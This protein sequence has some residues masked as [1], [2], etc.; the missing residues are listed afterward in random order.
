M[1]KNIVI[2]DE[3]YK[4]NFRVAAVFIDQ[5]KVLLQSSERDSYLFLPGGRVQ[6]NETTTEA[7]QREILEEMGI[8]I[9]DSEMTLIHVAENFFTHDDK[10]FHELLFI[11]RIHNKEISKKEEIRVLD[12]T[13]VTN[14]WYPITA[15]KKMDVRPSMIVNSIQTKR[16][17]HDIIK[18]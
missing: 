14:K 9:K 5:D 6:Y 12:K 16:I 15:L 4:F 11:Y 13:D 17:I 18:D 10:K 1:E 2:K 7:L 8:R 3:E